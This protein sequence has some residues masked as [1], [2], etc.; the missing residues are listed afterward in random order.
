MYCLIIYELN[1]PINLVNT[2]AKHQLQ[3]E[4]VTAALSTHLITY[5]CAE[6]CKVWSRV[7]RLMKFQ[8][9]LQ[10]K[11]ATHVG[12]HHKEKAGIAREDLITKVVHT[13][14]SAKG[15]VLLKIPESL[16]VA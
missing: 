4:A 5:F 10:R 6:N 13:T 15:T 8:H 3:T 16:T 2:S 14:S 12:V 1:T 9:F 11:V 7:H